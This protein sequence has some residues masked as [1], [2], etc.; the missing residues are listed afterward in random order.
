MKAVLVGA[1]HAGKTSI[2]SRFITNQFT[3]NSVTSVQA[4]FFQ[5]KVKIPPNID[6]TL[7]IWDTAGQ[8]RFHSLA[9]MYYRD[10]DIVL[11]VFDVTDASSFAKAKHWVTELRENAESAVLILV[12]NKCD[13]QT[14]RVVPASE[15]SQYT[16]AARLPCLETSARTGFQIPEL[17][18]LAVSEAHAHRRARTAPEPLAPAE[19]PARASCC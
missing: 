12:A 18:E 6:V 13:V 16:K 9:P 17:F 14:L 3:L 8:E 15:I 10:A 2:V 1:A 19:T 5:K 4:A 11:I 7:D